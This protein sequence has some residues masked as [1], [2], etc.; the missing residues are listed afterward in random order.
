MSAIEPANGLPDWMQPVVEGSRS[1]TAEQLTRFV[2]PDDFSGRWGAVLMLFA[3]REVEY[4][5]DVEDD[6][7]HRGEIL[8]TERSHTMRSHPGQVSFPGGGMDPGETVAEAALREAYEEVGLDPSGVEIFGQL[9]ELW[10]PPSNYAVTPVLGWWRERTP[11]RA[12][13]DEVESIHHVSIA[14][15]MDPDNRVTVT[16]PSGWTGPAFLIGEK[17]DVVLWGFTAGIIS[18][19]F[20]HLGW[21]L[22]WDNAQVRDLPAH[23][24]QGVER[25]GP[26]PA[27]NTKYEE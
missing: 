4:G 21:T 10:L 27:P 2:P 9:P 15:L 18:R 5:I 3:D 13:P 24:L 22:S 11:V 16:H 19:L 7:L 26:R 6:F 8:L 20:D 14:E 17:K 25:N 23:M 1:I 12:S